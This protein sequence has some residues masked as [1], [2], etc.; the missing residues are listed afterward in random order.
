[1]ADL[2]T[3]AQVT[4]RL[5]P[6]FTT[7]AVQVAAFIEDASALVREAAEG[8]LDDVDHTTPPDPAIVPVVV[9]AVRRALVNPDQN[10]QEQIGN[11]SV[12]AGVT[13]GVYLT[14]DE[15]RTVR[16]AVGKLSAGHAN[17]EGFIPS[18]SSTFGTAF[19][20]KI[21]DSL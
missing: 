20:D 14:R 12:T 15:R 17:L 21:V 11:Y 2:V 6:D 5:G 4:D 7:D 3:D 1:M 10:R 18:T 16:K 9:S 8:E 13:S 19:E